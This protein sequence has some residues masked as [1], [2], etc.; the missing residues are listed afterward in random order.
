MKKLLPLLIFVLLI[1]VGCIKETEINQLND[2]DLYTLFTNTSLS[3]NIND[4]AYRELNE[5]GY[6]DK[7]RIEREKKAEELLQ[8]LFKN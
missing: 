5:R 3:T 6:W 2:E 8:E 7:E 1:G 4:E